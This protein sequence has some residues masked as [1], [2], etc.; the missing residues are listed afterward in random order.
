MLWRS[1]K[2]LTPA[3]NETTILWPPNP[4]LTYWAIPGPS[5]SG[6]RISNLFIVCSRKNREI[7]VLQPMGAMTLRHQTLCIKKMPSTMFKHWML[8]DYTVLLVFCELLWAL[9]SVTKGIKISKYHIT[10][11]CTNCMSFI[12][13]HFF[14][15]LSL[16]LHVSIAYRLSSPG[17]TYSS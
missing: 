9:N 6:R 13:N 14:K 7:N 8:Y 17:S 4:Q 12:L 16:L 15:T 3:R 10:N 2:L 1:G 11:K 5:I